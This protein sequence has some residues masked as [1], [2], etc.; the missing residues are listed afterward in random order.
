MEMENAFTSRLVGSFTSQILILL[1]AS[2][3]FSSLSLSRVASEE[4]NKFFAPHDPRCP[5]IGASDPK[6]PMHV[7]ERTKSIN[8]GYLFLTRDWVSEF[9]EAILSTIHLSLRYYEYGG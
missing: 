9:D 3:L 5:L 4:S 6:A 2:F 8:S 1:A 7:Q